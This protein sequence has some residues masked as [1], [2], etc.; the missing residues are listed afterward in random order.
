MSTLSKKEL[1][2][3]ISSVHLKK[4][5]YYL[6]GKQHNVSFKSS[7]FI[8]KPEIFDL[9]HFNVFGPMKTRSLGGASYFITFIDD[10]S[11]KV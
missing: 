11:K 4:C 1:I 2:S 10:H 3:R 5:G 6:V 8:R 7:S 9:I